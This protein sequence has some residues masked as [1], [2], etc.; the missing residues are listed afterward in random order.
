MNKIRVLL[1]DDHVVVRKGLIHVLANYPE[2][3]VVGEAESGEEALFVSGKLSPDVI[4]MDVKMDGLGGVKT[5]RLITEGNA[6][7]RVIGLSTFSD[8]ATVNAMIDAGASGFLDKTVSVSELV[9]AIHRAH[10][11][12]ILKYPDHMSAEVSMPSSTVQN[13][14][15][16]FKPDFG[17]KQQRVLTLLTKGFTNREI[18]EQIGV[19]VPTARYHVSVILQKLEASNRSE[20]AA[21][22]VRG[23]LV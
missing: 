7:V 11:G 9:Q 5:T 21:L 2:I 19:S 1:V 10:A 6:D 16:N 13:S 12:D 20:A 14:S 18:A 17:E 4:M 22:A 3:E 23:N 8:H 15:Q